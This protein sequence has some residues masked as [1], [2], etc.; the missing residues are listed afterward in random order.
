MMPSG[1]TC[2]GVEYFCFEGM[3][4]GAHARQR[5]PIG[6]GKARPNRPDHAP[7]VCYAALLAVG[8]LRRTSAAQISPNPTRIQK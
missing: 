7:Q 4:S 2:L 8:P 3:R 1:R 5:G 6:E